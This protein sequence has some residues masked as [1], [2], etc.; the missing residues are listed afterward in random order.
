[1]GEI[2]DGTISGF[3]PSTTAFIVHYPGYPSSASRAVETLG[4]SEGIMKAR[5][6]DSNKLELRFR[7]EDPFCHPAS[8]KLHHCNNFLLKIYRRSKSFT[9]AKATPSHNDV[10]NLRIEQPGEQARDSVSS[11]TEDKTRICANITAHVQEEYHFTGMA[12]YQ[13]VVAVHADIARKKKRKGREPGQHYFEK[14]GPSNF[15]CDDVMMLVPPL[16][17]P[18]DA[19]TTVVLNYRPSMSSSRKKLDGDGKLNEVLGERSLALDFKIE[20]ILEF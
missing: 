5:S 6:S 18:K 17:S 15:G 19:P 13:H 8:G 20:D 4:G 7:P 3:L 14:Y 16:F 12:D 2:K 9:N 10:S 11:V 1:M